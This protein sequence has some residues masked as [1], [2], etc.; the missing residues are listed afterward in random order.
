MTRKRRR[1]DRPLADRSRE[2][3]EELGRGAPRVSRF[4]K[5]EE[6][7]AG[8][9]AGVRAAGDSDRPAG[10]HAAPEHPTDEPRAEIDI[11][12]V[13]DTVAEDP[14]APEPTAVPRR[15]RRE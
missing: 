4:G 2:A 12:Q 10:T 15:R 14:D 3:Q 1:G 5:Q 11:D 6:A 13:F 9:A 7:D 8:F